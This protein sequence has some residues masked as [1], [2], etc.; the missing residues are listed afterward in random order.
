MLFR[1]KGAGGFEASH[2]NLPLLILVIIA[3]AEAVGTFFWFLKKFGEIA[4][5]PPSAAV[6][7]AKP[8]PISMTAAIVALA[9][10]T[11]CSGLVPYA[12]LGYAG[13]G[14]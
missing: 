5:G 14:R 2:F 13:N 4:F 10:L 8:L 1:S 11:L 9:S 12:W 3:I 6:A 7:A